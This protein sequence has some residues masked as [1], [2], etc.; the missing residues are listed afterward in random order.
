MPYL[1]A[2]RR[3]PAYDQTVNGITVGPSAE[4]RFSVTCQPGTAQQVPIEQ[5]DQAA[6]A[7]VMI[8]AKYLPAGAV[9][10]EAVATVCQTPSN[11]QAVV[12]VDAGFS[13]PS[14]PKIGR[15]GGVVTVSRWLGAPSAT[16]NIPAER[17]AA[18]RI[19]GRPAAIARP[20]L[21]NGLG[22]SAV[23]VHANGV[24]TKVQAGWLTLDEVQRIAEGLF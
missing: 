21:A 15:R 1:E 19:A 22:Q 13:I 10:F 6:A 24:T 2:D 8:A 9:R 18:G 20:I 12:A 14:D 23:V 4:H 11:Q 3:K 5:V 17:W 7:P 16:V